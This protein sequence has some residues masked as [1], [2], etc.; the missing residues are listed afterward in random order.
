[1]YWRHYTILG[2]IA[3]LILIAGCSTLIKEPEINVTDVVV[4]SVTLQEIGLNVTLNVNNP[5]PVGIT[6]KSVVFDVYYQKGND[7]VSI[8]HG[9]G[10]GYD[11]KPGM[12]E[13]S[14]PVTI[15]TSD[16]LGAGIG[17]LMNGE[18]T[19]QIRGTA[20]PDLFGL[21]PKIPFSHTTTIPVKL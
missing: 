16:L 20:V 1:M 19:L 13:I 10:G 3:A 17:A 15:K 7:W 9:E 5:N 21:N 4:Q 18:I 2:L 12:N 8:G 6:L 14:I 11:I